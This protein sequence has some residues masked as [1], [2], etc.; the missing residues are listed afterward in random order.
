MELFKNICSMVSQSQDKTILSDKNGEYGMIEIWD[1]SGRVYRYLVEHGIEREDVVMVLLPRC[2][3]S[4][5]VAIGIWRA[6]AAVTML[7]D[8][9]STEWTEYLKADTKCKIVIDT[10]LLDDILNT[11]PLEGWKEPDL[12]DLAYITYTTGTTGE[13]KGVMHEYG[14]LG[15]IIDSSKSSF[16]GWTAPQSYRIALMISLH[17]AISSIVLSIAYG[18]YMDI[19]PCEVVADSEAFMRRMVRKKIM[20]TFMSP[21]MLEKIGHL[22]SPYLECV[23]TSFEP[24]TN[25]CSSSVPMVNE[26]GMTEAGGV[27]FEFLIDKEYEI[28]PI[29]KPLWPDE[30]FILDKNDERVT[31]GEIGEICFVNHFCR[32]YLNMP[33]ATASQFRNGLFHTRD[34]GKVLP[35]GN[36]VMLGRVNDSIAT[37]SGLVV[38]LEIEALSRDVMRYHNIYVKVFDGSTAGRGEPV[39]CVYADKQL[40]LRVLRERLALH[41]PEYKLPTDFV[42]VDS[43]K[44][45]NGKVIRL[46]LSNPYEKGILL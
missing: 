16:D 27:L 35:D 44:Y 31:N 36:W 7:E 38:A 42:K 23:G 43:F 17:S 26:Y 28:V 29:G 10:G 39:I 20:Y 25:I 45:N 5:M 37:P 1:I 14:T 13:R 19:V 46:E 24:A 34:L 2:A 18:M 11:E 40:D 6:G 4:I 21:V 41:L 22:D 33:D 15:R 9:T 12:H 32:G 3:K 8:R 30:T